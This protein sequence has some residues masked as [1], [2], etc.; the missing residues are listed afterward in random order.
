[1]NKAVSGCVLR[2]TSRSG[3]RTPALIE[4]EL[5][6]IVVADGKVI[7]RTALFRAVGFT[8][9][10]KAPRRLIAL[11]GLAL[12][13]G[14]SNSFPFLPFGMMWQLPATLRGVAAVKTAK[15]SRAE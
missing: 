12:Q 13:K 14:D 10:R 8:N 15:L 9:T 6:R 4:N 2:W 1:L 7:V 3:L 5:I 11:L